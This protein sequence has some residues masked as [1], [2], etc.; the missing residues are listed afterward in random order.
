MVPVS[1][2][3]KGLKCGSLKYF[4]HWGWYGRVRRT[5]RGHTPKAAN[6]SGPGHLYVTSGYSDI[7][8]ATCLL[9]RSQWTSEMREKRL[10]L[11]LMYKGSKFLCCSN[12]G[13]FAVKVWR[14]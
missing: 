6:D 1:A 9:I 2:L 4:G 3:I 5:G 11:R 7:I 14:L 8:I 12:V 10:K 13:F